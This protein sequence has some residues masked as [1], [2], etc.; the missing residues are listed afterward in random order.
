MPLPVPLAGLTVIQ[1]AEAIADH[2]QTDALAAT[3]IVAVTAAPDLV[4][5]AGDTVNVH[6]PAAWLIV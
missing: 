3:E 1:L 2:V 6:V 4:T 5:E